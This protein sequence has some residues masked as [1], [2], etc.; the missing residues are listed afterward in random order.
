M[1]S[2]FEWARVLFAMGLLTAM[3][4]YPVLFLWRDGRKQRGEPRNID[5]CGPAEDDPWL[6]AEPSGRQTEAEM[7]PDACSASGSPSALTAQSD[8][9]RNSTTSR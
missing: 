8:V 1:S 2:D 3:F 7:Q 5:G 6:G 9:W 4:L